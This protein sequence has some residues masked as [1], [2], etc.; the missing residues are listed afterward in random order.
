MINLNQ[1]EFPEEIILI[2]K[3]KLESLIELIDKPT[4]DFL[5]KVLSIEI[6]QEIEMDWQ[7]NFTDLRYE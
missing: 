6:A 3:K 2:A 7:E 4:Y 1:R 5:L